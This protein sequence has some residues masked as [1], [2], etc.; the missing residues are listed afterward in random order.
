MVR[1][2][3]VVADSHKFAV[4]FGPAKD[5]EAQVCKMLLLSLLYT[6]RCFTTILLYCSL[7]FDV[8]WQSWLQLLPISRFWIPR[9]A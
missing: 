3:T 8:I 6:I 1:D 5:Q 4:Y 9:P 7:L 2:V